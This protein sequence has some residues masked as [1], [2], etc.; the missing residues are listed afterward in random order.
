MRAKIVLHGRYKDL[1]GEIFTITGLRPSMGRALVKSASRPNEAPLSMSL[2][3]LEGALTRIPKEKK[4][5]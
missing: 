3:F 1:K 2:A 4:K 5:P